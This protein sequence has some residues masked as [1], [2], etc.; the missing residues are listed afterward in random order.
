MSSAERPVQQLL[1]RGRNRNRG[2]SRAGEVKMEKTFFDER[3]RSKKNPRETVTLSRGS[4]GEPA[5]LHK[6]IRRVHTFLCRVP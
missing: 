6:S 5:F 1:C 4:C 2:D 3:L